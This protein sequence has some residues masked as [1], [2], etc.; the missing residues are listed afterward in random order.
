MDA[1]P[2]KREEIRQTLISMY[3]KIRKEKGCLTYRIFQN[4]REQYS[5]SSFGEW[6]TRSSL[7]EHLKS[8]IFSVML[9]MNSLLSSPMQIRIMTVTQ[10]EG[11]ELAKTIR[12]NC[13]PLT[14]F[15]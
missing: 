14:V 3:D 10:S 9:G 8:D 6:T 15:D 13:V 12:K 7:L 11:M 4:I 5:F 1:L 2:D